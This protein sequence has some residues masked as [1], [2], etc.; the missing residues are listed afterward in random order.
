MTKKVPSQGFEVI[1]KVRIADCSFTYENSSMI[2]LLKQRGTDIK[3]CDWEALDKTSQ[4]LD[5]LKT[6]KYK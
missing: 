3:N 6:S 5:E 4:K 1:D 2:K